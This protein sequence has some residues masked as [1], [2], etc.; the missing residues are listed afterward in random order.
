MSPLEIIAVCLGLANIALLI[1]RSIWNYPF[2]L[3]MVALY[4]VIFFT[5]RLYSDA[6][7]QIFFFVLQLY[8]W[9]A[10]GQ[11]EGDEDGNV[12]VERLTAAQWGMYLGGAACAAAAWGTL[13]HR[14][15]DAAA[16][17]WDATIA[18]LSITAQIMLARRYLENWMLWIAV[19]VIAIPLYWSRG[20]PLTAG[21]YGLFL[22][23]SAIGLRAWWRMRPGT[24]AVAA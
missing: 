5:A 15:T 8:G 1:R 18:M 22:V 21:L 16:P 4:G 11:A 13:M 17:W 10:W 14:F 20:L 3:A 9:W 12:R 2:G 23:M 24:A 7:L 19:D 6:L